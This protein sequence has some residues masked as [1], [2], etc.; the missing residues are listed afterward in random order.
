M[1]IQFL[2]KD[3]LEEAL[4]L[5]WNVFSE[6]EAPD[7][8]EEGI[9]TFQEFIEYSTTAEQVEKK[10]KIFWGYYIEDAL[11]G[12]IAIRDKSH[13]SLLFVKKEYH[14]QG[15]GRQLV[16]AVLS[17]CNQKSDIK[18]LTV[19]SSPYATGFYH[20]MGFRDLGQQRIKD[21]IIF[22]PMTHKVE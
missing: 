21:G 10:Q 2:S 4:Q 14:R 7:Y 18:E 5:S 17:Y 12:V 9:R 20:K 3:K 19:N 16:D 6:F 22:T 13:I 8:S 15:V 11:V 1:S